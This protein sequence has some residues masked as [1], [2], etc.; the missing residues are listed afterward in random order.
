MIVTRLQSKIL[1]SAIH[2]G[3]VDSLAL[4]QYQHIDGQRLVLPGNMFIAIMRLWI[5]LWSYP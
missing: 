4:W 1:C 5:S 2:E 3:V